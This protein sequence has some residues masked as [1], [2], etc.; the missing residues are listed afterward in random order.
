MPPQ[1]TTRRFQKHNMGLRRCPS[2]ARV[3]RVPVV[4]ITS[5]PPCLPPTPP[6]PPSPPPQPCPLGRTRN[7]NYPNYCNSL[8][9][10]TM[11]L[12]L[13]SFF[14]AI[15]FSIA[16]LC[17]RMR[18]TCKVQAQPSQAKPPVGGAVRCGAEKWG[19]YNAV[20]CGT[21]RYNAVR[22]ERCGEVRGEGR[23]AARQISFAMAVW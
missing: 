20:R 7:K 6:T 4:P 12:L 17:S 14:S 9:S 18:A 10:Q 5:R 21:M 22:S 16:L 1:A 2:S 15:C 19:R 13:F 8:T 23:G 3:C 11:S